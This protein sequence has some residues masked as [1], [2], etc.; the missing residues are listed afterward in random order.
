[1]K[2]LLQKQ[3]VPWVQPQQWAQGSGCLL[4]LRF[5]FFSFSLPPL[6]FFFYFFNEL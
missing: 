2:S 4:R 1:M 5:G 6:F 3:Q